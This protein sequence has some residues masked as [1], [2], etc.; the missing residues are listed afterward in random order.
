[1]GAVVGGK[2]NDGVAVQPLL[3]QAVHQPSQVFVQTGA[4]SQIVGVLLG[5]V[6]LEHLQVVGQDK[7][8]VLLLGADGTLVVVMVI[9]VMGLDLGNGHK[10]GLFPVVGVE[11]LQ[12]QIGD[13]VGAVALEINAVVVFVKYE[14]VIAVGGELQ[15]VG[16]PPKARVAAPQLP[17]NGGDGVVDGGRLLQF[18]VAGQVPLADIGGLIARIFDV[19]GQRLDIAGQHDVVAEAARLSGIFAGLEQG[20]A[21]AAHRLGGKRVVKLYALLGQLVQIGGDIQRLTETAAGVPALLVGEI[22]YDVIGHSKVLLI[23]HG[24]LFRPDGP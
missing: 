23:Q 13:A 4:L 22:E 19:V 18:A 14:P 5:G 17:G 10:E 24:P 20:A 3:F 9:L 16:G 12:G 15:H 7:V 2:D 11:E 21:G 1:M 6:A 8:L